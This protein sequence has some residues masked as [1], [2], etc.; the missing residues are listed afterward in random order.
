[1]ETGL[2]TSLNSSNL[3]S[4]SL[5][6]RRSI[7]FNAVT[8]GTPVAPMSFMVSRQTETFRFIS[9]ISSLMSTTRRMTSENIVSSRVDLKASTRVIGS[10]SMKPTV[11]VSK[12]L[13]LERAIALVLVESVVKSP[14]SVVTFSLVNVFLRN[15]S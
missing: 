15:I 9:S 2:G 14:W 8:M 13:F 1:M 5:L 10:L 6:V 12:A 3:S 11:S 4:T 7:L